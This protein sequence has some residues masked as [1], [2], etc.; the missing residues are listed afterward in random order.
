MD[1]SRFEEIKKEYGSVAS[2]AIWKEKETKET[3]EKS[4]IGVVLID[5]TLVNPNVIFVGLNISAKISEPFGNFHSKSSN[6]HDYKIRYAL[7]DTMFW[8]SYMTDIIKD[9]EQ[10]IS[11][12]VMKFLTKNPSFLQ[13]NLHA[14]EEELTFIGSSN[15][16]IIAFGNDCYKILKKHLTHKIYKVSHYSSRINKED[17]RLQIE[18]IINGIRIEN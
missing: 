5:H 16:I 2:W 17:L 11:G 8:G 4:N 6:S 1:L 10:K 15:P 13:E 12:N 3:K 18:T 7:K 14:F 9:F